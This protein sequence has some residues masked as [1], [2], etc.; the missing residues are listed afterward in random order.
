MNGEL[1]LLNALNVSPTSRAQ[2]SLCQL[3]S[4]SHGGEY[5]EE[6]P[7]NYSY[8][9]PLLETTGTHEHPAKL[10]LHS[11]LD[12]KPTYIC[13]KTCLASLS[14]FPLPAQWYPQKAR[15]E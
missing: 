12:L 7:D 9:V 14:S 6:T 1:Q 2:I 5:P 8:S 13:I 11:G 3:V 10:L 4:M 15:E